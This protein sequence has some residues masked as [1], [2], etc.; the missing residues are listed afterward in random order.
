MKSSG[1]K[2]LRSTALVM[3]LAV[4]AKA[5]GLVREIIVAAQFGTSEQMDAFLVAATIAS[6]IFVW[7]RSPIRVAFVP[8]FIDELNAQ[9]ERSAWE[10][11]SVII[12]TVSVFLVIFAAIGWLLSRYL[13]WLLAPG[14]S[15]ETKLLAADLT[16]LMMLSIVFLG[17]AK[18]L[19]AVFHSYQRF[20]WPGM[21]STA[22]NLVMIPSIIL[23]TPLVGIYGL[24][25]STVL[26]TLAQAIVQTPIL[27]KHRS[28]YKPKV[29]F[30]DPTLRRM[31]W[32]G[33]P[34]LI[35]TGSTKLASVIDRIFA[36]LLRPG[37]LSALSYGHR[38]TYVILELFVNSFTTVLFPL[39]SKMAGSEDYKDFG[40]K[41]FKSIR[42]L[43]WIG[44]PVSVGILVLHEPLV[45]LV[46]QRGAF[47]EESVSLTSEAVV[48][49]AIGLWAYSLSHVLSFA[50]Y[51]LKDT[52]TPVVLGLVRLGIKILLSFALIGPMAHAGLALAESL[53]YIV[54]AA[55]LLLFLP[56]ELRG[57]LEYRAVFQSFGTTALITA[58][59]GAVVFFILPIFEGISG[60]SSFI[61]NSIGLGGA[62]AVGAGAY[63]T[64][65]S[66]LQPAELT[67]LWRVVRSGFAKR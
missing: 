39:F 12:N 45:R 32:M 10:K 11:G 28:Y 25:I 20:G 49:Y 19:S 40:K 18:L 66:L 24:V 17:I 47:S 30:T 57:Q 26:G 21:I 1:Q 53:S 15:Q 50:F 33:F 58:G 51:S 6:L 35:G 23:L 44:F 34:L 16:G 22:D 14:F 63:L 61:A 37:S 43:F 5:T 31:G 2:I 38:L 46:F 64:F 67:D 13:V 52:K 48:F 8:F 7:L 36:S 54:K 55:L 41:L 62:V 29:D 65:S 56:E 4:T 60:G 27:W 3:A 59:M 42:T 9:G